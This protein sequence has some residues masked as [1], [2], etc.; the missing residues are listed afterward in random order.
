LARYRQDPYPTTD[1]GEI[2]QEKL[3]NLGSHLLET[4]FQGRWYAMIQ[5]YTDFCFVRDTHS[6]NLLYYEWLCAQLGITIEKN[7]EI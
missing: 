3:E 5:A 2:T 1:D 6:S 7:V 4:K